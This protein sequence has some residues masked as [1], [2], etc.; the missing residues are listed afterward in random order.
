M[1]LLL[2]ALAISPRASGGTLTLPGV[3]ASGSVTYTGGG[4]APR[5]SPVEQVVHDLKTIAASG[6]ATVSDEQKQSLADDLAALTDGLVK[7]SSSSVDQLADDLA[8]AAA[9]GRLTSRSEA[10]LAA[11][12]AA[13]FKRTSL[14]PSRLQSVLAEIQTVLSAYG[15]DPADLQQ[16]AAD[17]AAIIDGFET[18]RVTTRQH[19]ALHAEN[20]SP[21]LSPG[22]WG[23][24][25]LVVSR[26]AGQPAQTVLSVVAAGALAVNPYTVAVTKRSDGS[27][28]ALGRLKSHPIGEELVFTGPAGIGSG[29]TTIRY[30]EAVF[31]GPDGKPLPEGF[32]PADVALVTITDGGGTERL[33]GSFADASNWSGSARL[34]NLHLD[35]GEA[36]PDA[37]GSVSF[38]VKTTAAKTRTAFLLY[39]SGLPANAPV[40]LV[41]DGVAAGTFTTTPQGRLVIAEGNVPVPTKP[42]GRMLPVNALP[43]AV[44]LNTVNALS[45]TDAAG[46]V[47]ASG[48]L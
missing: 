21:Y 2:A 12:L 45:L 27:T 5:L 1:I 6:A 31:G 26:Q 7:P 34:V 25:K 22:Y 10:I 35:A 37:A 48:S 16:I 38:R 43:A 11:D 28:L 29:L 4:S 20:V 47:L 41:A 44:D 18:N 19:I 30:G 24:A 46:S 13:V 15:I 40:T 33:V 8:A 36:A 23:G 42:S 14:S 3:S 17:L 39:A 9:S 32:D